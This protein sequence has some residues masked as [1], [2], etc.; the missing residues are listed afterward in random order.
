MIFSDL[1]QNND[2]KD[3]IFF[4]SLDVNLSNLP[5]NY[6]GQY[7]YWRIPSIDQ[8]SREYGRVVYLDSD[9]YAL[10]DEI[11]SI[12]ELDLRDR[13]LGATYDFF[14]WLRPWLR[15][16]EF[17]ISGLSSSRYFNSG[18]LLVDCHKWLNDGFS[19]KCL[20][21]ADDFPEAIT[22]ADQSV[23]NIAFIDQWTEIS[24]DWNWQFTTKAHA[25][26]NIDQV[27][28][29]HFCGPNKPWSDPNQKLPLCVTS[30]WK[31]FQSTRDL[32]DGVH[33]A[34]ASPRLD[35]K[36]LVYSL[37]MRSLKRG[38]PHDTITI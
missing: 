21:V 16:R 14:E 8:A 20:K 6:L 25:Q 35:A 27:R 33:M 32:V 1:V 7:A 9:F 15:P 37:R 36:S 12:F 38:F 28:L 10:G 34:T 13:A 18:L 4:R 17:R 22:R 2:T 26:L 5:L 19:E 31:M 24:P 29:L 30:D 3:N 11:D 23:L